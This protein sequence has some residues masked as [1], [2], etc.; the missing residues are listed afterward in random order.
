[1]FTTKVSVVAVKAP[2]FLTISKLSNITAPSSLTS[3]MRLLTA[4]KKFLQNAV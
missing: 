2:A 3:N 4:V 1:M